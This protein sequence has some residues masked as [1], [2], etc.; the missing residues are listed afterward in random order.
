MSGSPIRTTWKEERRLLLLKEGKM[1][2]TRKQQIPLYKGAGL[3]FHSLIHLD[4]RSFIEKISNDSLLSP[5]T[6]RPRNIVSFLK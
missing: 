3:L 2:G 1:Q 5:N 6:A 4:T